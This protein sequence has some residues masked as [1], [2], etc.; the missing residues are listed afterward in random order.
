MAIALTAMLVGNSAG[1]VE[2]AAGFPGVIALPDGF[3]PEGIAVGGGHS[4]YAGS[5]PTGAIFKGDLR[6]GA[7][8][9]L[10]PPTPG[11]AAIG[12]SVDHPERLFVAGGGTGQ[13]YVYDGKTG[14][15]LAT[16]TLA[17]PPD[18]FVND[19]VVTTD[20]AWFTDSF[21]AVLY[22]V[23]VA[24][25]GALATQA[26]VETVP[27]TG[28]FVQQAGFN[29]NGIDATPNGNT[30][31]VV[32]SGTGKLFAVDPATGVTTLIV[33]ADG[34][35]VLFGDGILLDGK[36]L[37]VVQNR[38]NL[39]ARVDLSANLASG[40]VVSRTG[41]PTFDV[42]TTV[43]EFGNRLYAVN[44]RFGPPPTPTTMYWITQIPKP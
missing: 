34:E 6:T 19:V 39:I 43:A 26:D 8:A 2:A 38:L 33:L 20:A 29:I 15:T 4:F 11:R 37:Y 13:A 5:I 23:P 18:M 42:P 14:A 24:R 12:L 30:L 32:Q 36:T 16:Y 25:S 10:V 40:V 44:A 27:L 35:S 41:A 1:H 21:R 3:R 22:R 17:N 7:G 28:D 9:Q 31:I